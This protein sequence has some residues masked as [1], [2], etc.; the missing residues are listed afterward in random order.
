M[1]KITKHGLILLFLFTISFSCK[2]GNDS[3]DKKKAELEKLKTDKEG[4]DTK[5]ATLQK[6]IDKLDTSAALEQKPKLVALTTLQP[7]P[8]K[9]YLQLQGTVDNRNVSFI[10]PTGQGGQIKAIYVKQGDHVKRGQLILKL[11]NEVAMQNVE[12]V[13]QQL[14]GVKA[15]LELAKS[16]YDRQKNLWEQHIGTEVQLLQDKTNVEALQNQLNT[17]QAQVNVSQTQAN[18]SNV[19]SDVNGVV[20][21]VTAHVGDY[22]NGGSIGAYIEIVNDEDLKITVNVPENYAGQVNKG[23]PVEVD[24]TDINKTFNGTISF[25]SQAIGVNSRGFNAEIKVPSDILLRPNE[26]AIVKILDYSDSSTIAI[27][28]NTLQNDEQGKFVL[29]AAKEGNNMVA[30]KRKVIVGKLSG[31]KIQITSG[32]QA[33]DQ[34]ITDGYQSLYDGQLITT[35]A[36]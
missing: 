35:T 4:L 12:A 30:R 21:T 9:H 1:Q 2:N 26:I 24:I 8:F 29:V 6:D 3:L 20:N 17:I 15:Q 36:A 27:D 5:I 33:G 10:A 14:G 18:Q 7:G 32:L 16:L 31:D 28:V 22:F 11:D 23:T 34:L 25:L 13:K 19:Y